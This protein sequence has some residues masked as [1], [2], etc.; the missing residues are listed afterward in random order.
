MRHAV[1]HPARDIIVGLDTERSRNGAT[2][3]FTA[4]PGG[5]YPDDCAQFAEILVAPQVS[6]PSIQKPIRLD[7]GVNVVD[8]VLRVSAGWTYN[9][10]LAQFTESNGTWFNFRGMN[11]V[12]SRGA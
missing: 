12:G 9:V 4:L 3:T 7:E 10:G 6:S 5:N 2:V 8:V 1:S 11:P